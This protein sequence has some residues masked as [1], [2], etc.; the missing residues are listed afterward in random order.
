MVDVAIVSSADQLRT[1]ILG[2]LHHT[3]GRFP[4]IASRNDWY[5]ALA[6]AVRQRV[7]DRWVQTVN[8]YFQHEVRTVS[9]LSAEFLIGPQLGL[10][11]LNLDLT[12]A[13]RQALAE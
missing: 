13:A 11:L 12:S 1:D 6:Y 8:S 9:Y 2:H 10:N 5:L 4:D 7:L 3:V